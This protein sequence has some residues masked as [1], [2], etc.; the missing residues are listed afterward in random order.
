MLFHTND[1]NDLKNEMNS[2]ILKKYINIKNFNQKLIQKQIY[3]DEILKNFLEQKM[4]DK[5]NFDR[6]KE[7]EKIKFNINFFKIIKFTNIRNK[8]KILINKKNEIE[9]IDNEL[10]EIFDKIIKIIKNDLDSWDGKLYFFY[11]PS[12]KEF[13]LKSEDISKQYVESIMRKHEIPFIDISE[14][15]Y[16]QQNPLEFFPFE[17]PGHYNELG[18]K[19]SNKIIQVVK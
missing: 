2:D 10:I 16:I 15:F 8:I 19:I 1:F 5:I 12:Q 3:I 6:I 17:M 4:Y 18:Y 9:V 13:K 7:K 14:L 11:L